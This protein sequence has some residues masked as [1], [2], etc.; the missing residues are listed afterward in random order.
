MTKTEKVSNGIVNFRRWCF[1]IAEFLFGMYCVFTFQIVSA[2]CLL[3]AGVVDLPAVRKKYPEKEKL[4]ITMSIVGWVF[5]ILFFD[6][7]GLE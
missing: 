6:A 2:A 5:G 3:C 4:F 1:I 7:S